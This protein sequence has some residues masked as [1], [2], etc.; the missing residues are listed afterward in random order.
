MFLGPRPS[1]PP[2]DG[3]AMITR[4]SFRNFKSLQ[5]VDIDFESRLT[6]LVGPNGSGKSSVL[7][8]LDLC[9]RV[10]SNGNP[11][12]G[13][14]GGAAFHGQGEAGVL[15]ALPEYL[16]SGKR[17]GDFRL[18]VSRRVDEAGTVVV[19]LAPPEPGPKP[20]LLARQPLAAVVKYQEEFDRPGAGPRRSAAEAVRQLPPAVLLRLDAN[21]LAL[22]S[23]P[24]A[25]PPRMGPDGAGLASVL[26][27]LALNQPD[28]FQAVITSFR[29][30]ISPVLRVRFDKVPQVGFADVLLFD[31]IGASGVKA[32]HTSMGT[33]FALGL[34]TALLGPGRPGVLLLD[35]L[36]HGLHPKAQ[37]ELVAVLRQFL[38]R[39]PDLQIVATSHS[40]Y[41]L[42]RLEWNEVRV[43]SLK[44]DG[45][46]VCVP[47]TDHP[48][49]ERWKEAMTPGEF[50]S[51]LGDEWVRKLDRKA[52]AVAAP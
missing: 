4:A 5:E 41:I 28:E 31:F 46:A 19:C 44:D 8:G 47:L 45:S 14:F 16:S 26:A 34:I 17:I 49:V 38:D 33:L 25:V 20:T 6:V 35:D 29:Q 21:H 10:T 22:P 3:L 27:Y 36:D 51:H 18:E 50:W 32:S 15:A 7:Q 13:F 42:D 43:T 39:Y 23:Q 12:P 30:V 48:D 1:R 9:C 37:M 40:P 2:F 11:E 24:Q 52:P